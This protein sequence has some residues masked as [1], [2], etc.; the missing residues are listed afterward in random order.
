MPTS[1]RG[2][3]VPLSLPRRWVTDI[4]HFGRR[5]PII[6]GERVL[7]LQA[8]AAA[9]KQVPHPPSWASIILKAFG[10]VSERV[11]ELRRSYVRFPWPRLHEMPYSVGTVVIDREY[12]GERGVFCAP[13]L[14]PEQLTLRQ[15]QAKTDAWKSDPIEKHGPLRRMVRTA[16]LPTP[17]R[18]ALWGY[19]IDWDGY[20]KGRYFG[21][22]AINCLAG[23][24]GRITQMCF[25]V[26]SYLYYGLPEKDGSMPIQFGFDHRVYD[27]A[28][29]GRAFSLLE[30][31][32]NR[33][34]L[35]EVV[36]LQPEADLPAAIQAA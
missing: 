31:T 25:P 1:S 18:R 10:L 27:G 28:T 7:R 24:R 23:M 33:E 13:M 30:E 17:V 21:T 6:T 14:H 4:L 15:I 5:V 2:R 36:A 8:V 12:N 29:C 35:A 34:V 3:T 11:P 16:K 9:R 26:T 32:L 20:L 19:A 22:F